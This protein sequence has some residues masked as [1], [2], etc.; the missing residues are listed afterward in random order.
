MKKFKKILS[1]IILICLIA[2]KSLVFAGGTD[3]Y[4]GYI[5]AVAEWDADLSITSND[6]YAEA[7]ILIDPYLPTNDIYCQI[8][9]YIIQRNPVTQ[10]IGVKEDHIIDYDDD[11]SVGLG[12]DSEYYIVSATSY[13]EAYCNGYIDD[14]NLSVGP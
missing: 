12:P 3:S 2:M 5:S 14:T 7:S 8:D 13:H 6:D 4:H 10:A 9:L 1:V 11:C